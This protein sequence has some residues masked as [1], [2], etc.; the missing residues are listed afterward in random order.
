MR[1]QI[2]ALHHRNVGQAGARE[3]AGL[4]VLTLPC[5]VVAMNAHV[6]LLAVPQLSEDLRPSG[7]SATNN[8]PGRFSGSLST[9]TVPPIA[10]MTVFTIHSQRPSPP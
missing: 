8:A 6:L 7:S 1:R 9:R 4:A 10:S 5:L 2:R 3:W